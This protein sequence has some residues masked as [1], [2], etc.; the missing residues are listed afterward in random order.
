MI[1]DFIVTVF[2]SILVT[3]KVQSPSAHTAY[4][5]YITYLTTFGKLLSINS[6]EETHHWRNFYLI[7]KLTVP[8][9]LI[10]QFKSRIMQHIRTLQYVLS[11]QS[12]YFYFENYLDFSACK[13]CLHLFCYL[14][15]FVKQ[16]NDLIRR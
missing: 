10:M 15:K 4:S 12:T 16:F 8:V 13:F 5:R 9:Q 6:S 11:I 3:L 1:Q 2:I 7:N 14:L